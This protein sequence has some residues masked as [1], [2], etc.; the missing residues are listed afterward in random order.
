MRVFLFEKT[1]N[2]MIETIVG[3]AGAVIGALLV[4]FG[5]KNSIKT[6]KQRLIKEAESEAERIK[7]DKMIQAKEK[8]VQLK[9]EHEK[10]I[11]AKDKKIK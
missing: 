7:K 5:L 11:L 3:I 6:E 1:N 4:Y 9:S 8:F 10:S 2:R